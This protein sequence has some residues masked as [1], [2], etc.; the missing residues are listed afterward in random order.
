[1]LLRIVNIDVFLGGQFLV[2]VIRL[3]LTNNMDFN[4]YHVSPLPIRIKGTDTKYIFIQPEIEYLL[5][6]TAKRYFSGLEVNE[7]HECKILNKD[8]KVYKQNKP[9]HLVHSEEV[10]EVQMTEPIRAIPSCSQIIV[11]LNH[12][13]W[14]QLHEREWLFVAPVLDVLTVLCV[15]HEPMDVT[16]SGTGRLNWSLCA[17]HM[18]EGC[19]SNPMPRLLAITLARICF[20]PFLWSTIVVT[21]WVRT[22]I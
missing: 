22:L 14:Q 16:L 9:M 2:H 13:L 5:M 17:R 19:S 11:D 1:M 20:L 18:E 15:K 6:D 3:P 4:L 21:V 10:C 8:W 7:I 12:T